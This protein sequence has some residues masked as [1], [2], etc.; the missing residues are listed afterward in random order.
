MSVPWHRRCPGECIELRNSKWLL[1]E[2]V[3]DLFHTKFP[4]VT[5]LEIVNFRFTNRT[6]A[7]E[8]ACGFPALE[9]LTFVPR[10]VHTLAAATRAEIPHTLRS[11]EL[12]CSPDEQPNWFLGDLAQPLTPAVT[13]LRVREAG[14]RD[15]PVMMRAVE[16]LGTSLSSFAL[17][18]ADAVVEVAFMQTYFLDKNTSLRRLELTLVSPRMIQLSTTFLSRA[19]LPA[20]EDL[21][22]DIWVDPR[23]FDLSDWGALDAVITNVPVGAPVPNVL[24]KIGALFTWAPLV[25]KVRERMPMCESMGVLRIRVDD[26]EE[27]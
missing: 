25:T 1:T 17:D 9:D 7:I 26:Q 5:V 10:V 11:L 6:A 15:F 8:F 22:L 21:V 18:F 3:R 13:T 19:T 23:N 24:L 2:D 14:V 4:S 27:C 12:R 20:L 16:H